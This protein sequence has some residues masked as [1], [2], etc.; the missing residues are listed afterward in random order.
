METSKIFTEETSSSRVSGFVF[1]IKLL[2]EIRKCL[3][4]SAAE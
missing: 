1:I 3:L 2:F 4:S